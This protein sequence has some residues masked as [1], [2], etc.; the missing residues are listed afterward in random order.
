MAFKE[1][2]ELRATAEVELA[3]GD[4][5]WSNERTMVLENA[6]VVV[7]WDHGGN[8]VAVRVPLAHCIA[9]DMYLHRSCLRKAD[10]QDGGEQ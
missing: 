8:Y 10:E 6:R 3:S 1:G 5:H 2:E 4:A 9:I 7:R